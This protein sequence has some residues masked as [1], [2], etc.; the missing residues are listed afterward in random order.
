MVLTP[1]LC[2][3][4]EGVT[5][6]CATPS[7]S[8]NHM[9]EK[10]ARYQDKKGIDTRRYKLTNYLYRVLLWISALDDFFFSFS[11]S[12]SLSLQ[13]YGEPKQCM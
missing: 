2:G 3:T 13:L 6:I 4:N 10:K 8:G 5:K 7:S 9:I 12:L 11:L 1:P